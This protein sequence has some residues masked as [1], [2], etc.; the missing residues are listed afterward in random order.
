MTRGPTPV[1]G[2]TPLDD[3][4]C[5]FEVWAPRRSSVAVRLVGSRREPIA[6]EP[7]GD[8]GF[9][10]TADGAGP[11]SRYVY[12]LDGTLERPDPASRHQPEGVHGPSEVVARPLVGGEG[13]G[14][15]RALDA[16]VLYEIHVG[17]FT[18]EGTFDAA[19]PHLDALADLGVTAI[20][21]MP[22]AQFPGERNWG[23]DGAYPFAVQSS[24]GGPE[25]FA[26]FVAACH[27]RGLAVVLDVVYNHLGPEGN[28]LADFGPYFTDRYRTP[29]GSAINFDGAGSDAVRRYFVEN[30]LMWIEDYGVDALRLD[31]V[32][33]IVDTSVRPFLAELTA[34]V[35][36]RA[37]AL[38]RRVHLVAESDAND[39]KVLR[40]ESGGGFGFE[41]QWNDDFHHALHVLVTGERSG[42]YQDFDGIG[43]LA[44]AFRGGF[45]QTGGRSRYRDRRHGAPAE[46]RDGSRFVVFAQNHDQVGNRLLGER[47]AA[48]VSLERLKLAAG[49]VLL[50][51]FTPLL[52]MGEEYGERAPFLY[53]VS[54]GDPALVEAVRRGRAREFERFSWNGTP[55]DPAA[56]ETFARCR[57]DRALA[58][59]EPNRTLLAFHREL[60]RL[61][62]ERPALRGRDLAG[63]EAAAW[64]RE[65][66]L[67]VLR[68]EDGEGDACFAVFNFGDRPFRIAPPVP[69]SDWS[70]ILDSGAPRWLGETESGPERF[71]ASRLAELT[72]AAAS[73]VV[74]GMR[75]S[76]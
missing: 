65:R 61:R 18:T 64:E 48:L 33:G 47:L 9:V 7:V 72:V 32:H 62:R 34:A 75:G 6:L 12:V 20:E 16:Y 70:K 23:Y 42:Y 56:A 58:S 17:T 41:G 30:A 40:S 26:R 76:D 21:V 8:G 50:S 27:L 2:A 31:A 10:G 24:Y 22:V 36:D 5:R 28:Y 51:P 67:C 68:R 38:G 49:A 54:H 43:G 46:T 45:V 52:F 53:F 59:R 71:D 39:P 14:R 1:L 69:A 3:G 11:G 66:A 44:K 35:R 19:I 63:V 74:Y 25:A 55:P 15:G 4:R 73:F 57:L 13:I 60:L 29:W 37:A